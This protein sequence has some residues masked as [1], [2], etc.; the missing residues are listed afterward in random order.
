V[1]NVNVLSVTLTV[2]MLTAVILRVITSFEQKEN[3][4]SL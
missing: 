1:L 2:V 3:F 4:E